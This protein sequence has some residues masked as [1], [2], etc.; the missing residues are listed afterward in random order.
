MFCLR[1]LSVENGSGGWGRLGI[2]A[3]QLARSL[4]SRIFES[5]ISKEVFSRRFPREETDGGKLDDVGSCS[6]VSQAWMVGVPATLRAVPPE[7]HY[8]HGFWRS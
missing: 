2:S 5:I 8:E 7:V 3:M 4:P 6:S 1:E